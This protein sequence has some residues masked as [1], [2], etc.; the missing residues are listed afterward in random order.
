[1]Y[2]Q[3]YYLLNILIISYQAIDEVPDQKSFFDSRAA[4][5][6]K[7]DRTPDALK[8]AKKVI[9]LVPDSWQVSTVFK[10]CFLFILF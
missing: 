1:M 8:D 6:D 3:Y 9:D 5:F 2:A 4:V 10:G 7:L